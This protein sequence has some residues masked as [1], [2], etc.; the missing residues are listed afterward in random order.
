MIRLRGRELP[1]DLYADLQQ[2]VQ[3]DTLHSRAADSSAPREGAFITVGANRPG[4][5][6]SEI[7]A[8]I[9]AELTAVPN[10]WVGG[11]AERFEAAMR[12]ALTEA[13]AAV[14]VMTD[15]P[16]IVEPLAEP[17]RQEYTVVGAL[18]ALASIIEHRQR[19]IPAVVLRI[20]RRGADISW[21]GE[22]ASGQTSVDGRDKFITKVN[23]GGWSHARYHRFA[24]NAW[25]RTATDT[26]EELERIV[27]EID[28]HVV[29][30]AAETRMAE[31]LR[32]HISPSVA[33]LLR[34]VPGAR[35]E[36]GSDEQREEEAKR[37]LRTAVAEESVELLQLFQ[38]RRHQP[39][40]SAVSGAEGTF[41]ALRAGQVDTLLI[42]DAGADEPMARFDW[43]D[44]LRVA[45]IG[46]VSDRSSRNGTS[47]DDYAGSIDASSTTGM[48]RRCDVAIRAALLSGAHVHIVPKG[49]RLD[50][51]IGALLRWANASPLGE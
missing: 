41:A 34:G 25:E 22:G 9:R 46:P 4:P 39:E 6:P 8:R 27:E 36:D 30:L 5:L 18:P 1:V 33:E 38:E 37:W 51:G 50:D 12:D 48:A 21:M 49:R 13:E 24:E 43:D 42:N 20:D 15:E 47:G 26:A 7:K 10:R 40:P 28:A 32:R 11:Q 31:M 3:T 19:D 2:Q 16:V 45:L 35:S 44:P 14:V 29:L 23:A 17:L